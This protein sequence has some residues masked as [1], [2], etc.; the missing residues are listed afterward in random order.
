[1]LYPNEQGGAKSNSS[2]PNDRCFVEGSADDVLIRQ[3]LKQTVND[4]ST[5]FWHPQKPCKCGGVIRSP[6]ELQGVAQTL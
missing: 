3:Q 1:M 2:K 5:D 6:V 4:F